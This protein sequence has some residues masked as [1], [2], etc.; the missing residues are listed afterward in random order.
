METKMRWW[1]HRGG[2]SYLIKTGLMAC[3]VLS[4]NNGIPPARS[5]VA[6]LTQSMNA[7]LNP[8]GK[9]SAPAS[10]TLTSTGTVFS[11]YG[12]TL[13]LLYRARTTPAGTGGTLTVQA[14]SDFS[15]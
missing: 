6:T 7:Q 15:P 8:L 3:A 5:D 9:I 13:T 10:L 11:P 4:A 2:R 12:G 1:P 14:T